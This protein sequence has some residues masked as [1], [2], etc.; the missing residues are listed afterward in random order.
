MFPAHRPRYPAAY[1]QVLG[2]GALDQDGRAYR[3]S[4]SGLSV[5]VAAPGVEVLSTTPPEGFSFADGTSIAAAHVSGVLAVLVSAGVEPLAARDALLE[6]VAPRPNA[7]LAERGGSRDPR[8]IDGL[9]LSPIC[10]VFGVL[11]RSCN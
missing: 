6:I 4:N 11:G 10:D 7:G 9:R 5:S 1:P 3:R 2:V 8:A